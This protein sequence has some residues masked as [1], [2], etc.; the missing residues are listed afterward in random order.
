VAV[1]LCSFIN[2][3]LIEDA[4]PAPDLGQD[5][6]PEDSEPFSTTGKL[7][8]YV[9][10]WSKRAN[11]RYA[12]LNCQN[13]SI[14][15]ARMLEILATETASVIPLIFHS[16]DYFSYL[17]M[18]LRPGRAYAI[19]DWDREH[20]EEIMRILGEGTHA[21]IGGYNPHFLGHL[22][23]YVYHKTEEGSFQFTI[24]DSYGG[25]YR[26]LALENPDKFFARYRPILTAMLFYN[27]KN[28][29]NFELD[30]TRRIVR[31]RYPW[32]A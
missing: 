25:S 15:T 30:E 14:A 24:V 27:A 9:L 29:G 26:T 10:E 4:K 5:R 2:R 3:Y 11:P 12:L 8:W 23:N 7:S 31:V 20:I 21:I 22:F 1:A 32:L 18:T 19:V 16:N 6:E 28:E 13:T 17:N